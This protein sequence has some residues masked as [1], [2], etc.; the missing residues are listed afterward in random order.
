MRDVGPF[1]AGMVRPALDSLERIFA[2]IAGSHPDLRQQLGAYGGF[3]VRLIRGT[4][5][6]A[7]RD[8]FGVALHGSIGGLLDAKGDGKTQSA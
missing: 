8:A 2:R 3:C 7:S 5:E 6:G 4:A 1:D